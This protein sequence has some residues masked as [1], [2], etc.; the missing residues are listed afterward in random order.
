[1]LDLKYVRENLQEVEKA[2]EKRG[3]KA[4][5]A[6]FSKIEVER[7]EILQKI[8]TLRNNRNIASGKIAEMKKAGEDAQ[9]SI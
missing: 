6:W 4:D 3:G 2:V 9:S 7:R 1:M 5:F 8:E